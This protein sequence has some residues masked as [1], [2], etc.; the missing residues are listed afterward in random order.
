MSTCVRIP[1]VSETT[2]WVARQIRRAR[3]D[4]GLSQSQLAARLGRTQ[5]AVSYW[6][7]GKRAPGLDDLVELPAPS[8][9]TSPTSCPDVRR[10]RRSGRSCGRRPSGSI[11]KIS[12]GSLQRLVDEAEALP[13]PVALIEISADTAGPSRARAL[14]HHADGSRRSTSSSWRATAGCT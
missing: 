14:Q 9:A 2:A 10:P 12:I 7:A 1:A 5:T 3:E 8:G 6:E 13:A 11:R 4:A